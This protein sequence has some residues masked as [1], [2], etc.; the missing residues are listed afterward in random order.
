[1]M[2]IAGLLLLLNVS[3]SIAFYGQA[4]QPNRSRALAF[5][6]GTVFLINATFL[7]TLLLRQ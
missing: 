4:A 1:M 7:L 6:L 3:W 5:L 2:L